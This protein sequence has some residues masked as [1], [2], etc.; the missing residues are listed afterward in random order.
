MKNKTI[1]KNKLLLAFLVFPLALLAK[2]VQ[3][4]FLSKKYFYDSEHILAVMNG[5]RFTDKS[6]SFT[7]NFF[8]AINV[9]GLSNIYQW[10]IALSSIATIVLFVYL[11][12]TKRVFTKKEYIFIYATIFLL[13]IYVFNLSKEIIQILIFAICALVINSGRIKDIKIKIALIS[14]IF[15]FESIYF[16]VYYLILATLVPIIYFFI[17]NDKK[18]KPIKVILIVLSVFL[19][20]TFIASVVLP[21]GYSQIIAAR[22]SVND[23][24]IEL[25]DKDAN[26]MIME[27]FGRNGNFLTFS[28]NY[29]LDFFRLIFPIELFVKGVKYSVFA[30]YQI[31][32]TSIVL[33]SLKI[34]KANTNEK[35]AL[36]IIIGFMMISA[37]FEPDFGS[38]IRHQCCVVPILACVYCS[39]SKEVRNVKKD[40]RRINGK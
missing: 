36:S 32:L 12:K 17:K 40:K 22:S 28:A 13:N 33:A 2:I 8:S 10:S 6:Y 38:Y 5:S 1:T 7:A 31:L 37:I 30:I 26:T 34:N 29:V 19:L 4:S 15:V 25:G 23:M 27:V 35:I 18:I 11:L 16:R 39:N 21:D 9:F 3:F 14:G 24:R 20:E